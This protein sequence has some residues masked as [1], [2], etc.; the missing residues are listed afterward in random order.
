MPISVWHLS[1][2][3]WSFLPFSFSPQLVHKH[4]REHGWS[5]S[6]VD[7]NQDRKIASERW[8]LLCQAAGD[9]FFPL[10]LKNKRTEIMFMS[11]W[12]FT[13]LQ[14]QFQVE[15]IRLR[16]IGRRERSNEDQVRMFSIQL[17]LT[18]T[19]KSFLKHKINRCWWKSWETK[20]TICGIA[21]S[22]GNLF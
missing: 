4:R 20:S 3:R 17:L 15:K 18:E 21:N 19:K 8:D 9:C 22:G 2:S 12:D 13:E 1:V 10:Q 5:R 16:M 14:I 11:C 6:G 7:R